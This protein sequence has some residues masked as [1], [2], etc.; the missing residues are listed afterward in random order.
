MALALSAG[1]GAAFVQGL[2][3]PRWCW[4]VV[5]GLLV[6]MMLNAL[7]GMM[8]REH[9]MTSKSGAVLNELGDVVSDA[10]VMWP[11]ALM[12][13][14]HAGWVGALLWLSVV[15]EYAGVLGSSL[16]TQRRYEGP[17]GK[18]DRTLV[19]GVLCISLGLGLNVTAVL[20]PVVYGVLACLGWSTWRR[21][22]KTIS[23]E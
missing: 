20:M 4:A 6:R 15:N 5:L 11:L 19:W 2:S 12:P 8:A 16:G 22:Q 17:M 1:L 7:D 10:L 14:M 9:G 21:I 13:G 3:D 23:D 18:S